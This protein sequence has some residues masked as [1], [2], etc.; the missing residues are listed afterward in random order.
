MYNGDW[1]YIDYI[2]HGLLGYAAEIISFVNS[3]NKSNNT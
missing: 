2:A 3:L 1:Y